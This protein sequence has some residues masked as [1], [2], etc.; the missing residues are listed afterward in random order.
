VQTLAAKKILETLSK[1][2]GT[3][4]S[5][6]RIRYGLNKKLLIRDLYIQD[7]NKDTLL[8][9]RRIEAALND[10]DLNSKKITLNSLKLKD[11]YGNINQENDSVYNY[12]FILKN[13]K[14]DDPKPFE[15]D[16]ECTNFSV[17]SS[18]L[19]FSTFKNQNHFVSNISIISSNIFIDSVHQDIS[20]TQMHFDLDDDHTLKSFNCEINKKNNW[21]KVKDLNLTSQNSFINLESGILKLP[22]HP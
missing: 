20:V 1:N 8:Y 22:M 21:I 18:A 12:T 15:W 10:L 5:I 7:Q 6:G 9:I 13:L 4:I 2:L 16:I 14:S 3:E 11:V 19:N 17:L